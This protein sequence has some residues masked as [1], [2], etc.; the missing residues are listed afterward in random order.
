MKPSCLI[1]IVTIL[2]RPLHESHGTWSVKPFQMFRIGSRSSFPRSTF[3]L[4]L[5]N[6]YIAT[7]AR[8][9]EMNEHKACSLGLKRKKETDLPH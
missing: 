5:Q 4:A 8:G 7:C 1:F 2:A 9:R 6:I 3:L